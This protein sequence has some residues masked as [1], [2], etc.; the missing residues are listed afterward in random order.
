MLW[1][2]PLDLTFYKAGGRGVDTGVHMQVV[3]VA[4]WEKT[5]E[6]SG[7]ISEWEMR[8]RRA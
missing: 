4:F 2:G 6:S 8:E 5:P 7:W 3:S 1:F